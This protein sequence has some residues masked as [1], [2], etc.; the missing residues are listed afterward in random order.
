MLTNSSLVFL[1][2]RHPTTPPTPPS[3]SLISTN[4]WI[5]ALYP[6][7]RG[8]MILHM[9]FYLVSPWSYGG[10]TVK[11]REKEEENSGEFEFFKNSM[12]FTWHPT[13][14]SLHNHGFFFLLTQ[15]ISCHLLP[16]RISCCAFCLIISKFSTQSLLCS[17]IRQL[18]SI[19]I[20][21]VLQ[22]TIILYKN[23]DLTN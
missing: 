10:S 20:I 14:I 2:C 8:S 1:S 18:S 16:L 4:I 12:L 13:C 17:P 7:F 6:L 5:L 19:I 11:K 22:N 9:G 21:I 3:L 23:N 15:P